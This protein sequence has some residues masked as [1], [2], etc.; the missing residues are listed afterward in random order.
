ME[1]EDNSPVLTAKAAA[2]L[3]TH[4][5]TVYNAMK[6]RSEQST[7]EGFTGPVYTGRLT[8]LFGELG[9]AVPY[10]TSVMAKLKLM[11]CTVQLRRGGGRSP[12]VWAIL[13]PPEMSEFEE[14]LGEHK[15]RIGTR[16]S[17]SEQLKQQIRDLAAEQ[18]RMRQ[19]ISLLKRIVLNEKGEDED[20]T[21]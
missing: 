2:S 17:T 13:A 11:N 8:Q 1:S 14:T 19:D 6:E 12:S 9:L 16:Q 10:Y 21:T 20:A 7:I 3:F 15:A 4:C 18:K 5:E